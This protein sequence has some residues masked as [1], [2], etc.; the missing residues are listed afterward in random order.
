MRKSSIFVVLAL[1]VAGLCMTAAA[2]ELRA[3]GCDDT[4]ALSYG[5][6]VAVTPP[7]L[8]HSNP[9]RRSVQR[10]LAIGATVVLASR[11][12]DSDVAVTRAAESRTRPAALCVLRC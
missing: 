8:Q 1:L 9:A 6:T 10:P 12:V 3:S 5:A 7:I 11:H 2:E 4:D